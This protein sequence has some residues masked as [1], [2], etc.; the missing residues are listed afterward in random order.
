M[1]HGITFR[2]DLLSINVCSQVICMLM[3]E[4]E[5]F[6][7]YCVKQYASSHIVEIFMALYEKILY[8]FRIRCFFFQF[9]SWVLQVRWDEIWV[10]QGFV[11]VKVQAFHCKVEGGRW[12]VL[13][14]SNLECIYIYTHISQFSFDQLSLSY[15]D[16]WID[17]C[18]GTDF[19]K[20]PKY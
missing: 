3:Y 4:G 15:L 12:V 18:F 17:L 1:Y 5:T 14:L 2:T 13:V 20:F 7:Y 10:F 8:F 16:F 6:G 19:S 11:R 9:H